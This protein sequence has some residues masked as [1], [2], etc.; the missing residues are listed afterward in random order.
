MSFRFM[1]PKAR[2]AV[3][4]NEESQRA[5]DALKDYL[6]NGAKEP[7]EFLVRFWSDQGTVI[8]Y[9]ELSSIIENEDVPEQVM[10]DWF[11]DYSKLLA[12]RITPLWIASMTEGWRSNPLF[13]D[14]GID[15]E[16]RT[17]ERN[18][19]QW[20]TRRAAELVTNCCEEQREAIRYLVAE[21][22]NQQMAPAETARYIRATI[23]L[24]QQQAAANL[25]YYHSIK[26]QLKKDHPRM[27]DETIEKKARRAAARYAQ[28]QHRYRAETIARTEMATAYHQGN[29]EAVRQAIEQGLMP[30]MKK[31]WSTANDGKVCAV[32]QALEGME[33]GM[34]AEFS[35]KVGTKVKRMVTAAL[36]PIHPRCGCAVKYV[37]VGQA[38]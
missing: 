36:P 2:R 4:K 7:M 26:E 15:F 31:V 35:V 34:D 25:N 23:G 1:F 20:L 19:R 24:T 37:E 38:R 27:T 30:S 21:C 6:D 9:A 10:N 3:R 5:L 32:C 22:M 13:Q 33:V 8:T 29:N 18:V 17:S 16:F 14:M 28:R 12:E 11:Q